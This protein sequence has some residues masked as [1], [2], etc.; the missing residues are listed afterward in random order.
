[1]LIGEIYKIRI[2]LLLELLILII[3]S[4]FDFVPFYFL[5][6]FLILSF[7]AYYSLKNPILSVYILM[8][9]ILVDALI[10]INIKST[11]PSL[12][13]VEFFLI[14]FISVISIKFFH[15]FAHF[16]Y[17]PNIILSWLPFLIWG[18]VI[19]L[20]VAVD[21]FRII[22]YWKNYFAGFFVFGLTYFSISNKSKLRYTIVS[23]IVWGFL[24]SMIEMKVFIEIG[25][26]AKGFLGLFLKK[27]LLD[28]GWGKSNY[29]AAFFVVIIPFTIG[30]LL[31]VRSKFGK[32]LITLALV[33]MSFALILT[34]SR[35][36]ILALLIALCILFPRT[37]KPKFFIPFFLILFSVSLV[38]IL[39]PLTYVIIDRISSLETSFSVFSRINYYKDVWRAFLEHPFTG[40]G[41]GN[42]SYYSTF[43]LGPDLSPSAHNIILGALGE[44]GIFGAIFYFV[45]FFLLIKKIYTDYKHE[46]DESLKILKWSF[47]SAILGGVIHSMVEPTFEGIQFSVIF[48][49]ISAIS[50]KLQ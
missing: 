15:N 14:F 8:L 41:F 12:L 38:V 22:S 16:I 31:Y 48:W 18:L 39:N 6:A 29:I 7:L 45:I 3:S 40:V 1:M 2:L 27:N 49:I 35:G 36:G 17:I 37:L 47:L 9:S 43:I 25:G 20:L 4:I 21:K 23:V 46:N 5:L 26:F 19:G 50:L 10:P 30:Y 34:L 13:I 24:L 42:L 11:G 33:F 32:F 44:L 28:V